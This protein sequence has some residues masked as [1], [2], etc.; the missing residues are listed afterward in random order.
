MTELPAVTDLRQ[1]SPDQIRLTLEIPPEMTVF[2]GHFPNQPILPGVAQI[3][4]A[5]HFSA[6]YLGCDAT[7]I[8]LEAIKFLQVIV[9]PAQVT[10][11]LHRHTD[12]VEFSYTAPTSKCQYSSGKCVFQRA[13]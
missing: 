7:F 8:G 4:W 2:S 6:R 11:M 13:S 9:P 1:L 12:T 10:L 3:D 5:M